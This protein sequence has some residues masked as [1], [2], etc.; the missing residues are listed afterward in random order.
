M[1]LS[2]TKLADS[3]SSSAPH[4]SP[5]HNEVSRRYTQQQSNQNLPS[6]HQ[7]PSSL[8]ATSSADLYPSTAARGNY[9]EAQYQG[10]PPT[11]SVSFGSSSK[12][13]VIG[14][15]GTRGAPSG[16][17]AAADHHRKLD[18]V[19]FEKGS[20]NR[21]QQPTHI[22]TA[23]LSQSYHQQ[24][25]WSPPSIY[26][27]PKLTTPLARRH[28]TFKPSPLSS[29]TFPERRLADD[30]DSNS[31]NSGGASNNDFTGLDL[32]PS[33][34]SSR[35]VLFDV[36]S[37]TDTP[38]PPGFMH[39][40]EN[41]DATTRAPSNQVNGRTSENGVQGVTR[42]ASDGPESGD[43][44]NLRS[45]GSIGKQSAISRSS[46]EG[47]SSY[48][49][50]HSHAPRVFSDYDVNSS[51]S[52]THGSAP[53][54]GGDARKSKKS[55]KPAPPELLVI[56]RPPPSKDR[57]PL[58]LQIQLVVP[59][60]PTPIISHAVSSESSRDSSAI[61]QRPPGE[62]TRRD[63]TSSSRSGTS[64]MTS[65]S[66]ASSTGGGRKVT[67]LY[68]LSFHTILPSTVL[69][70]GTDQKVAKF[71]KKGV[72]V[73]GFG[74]LEP[75]ELIRGLN[76]IQTL[77]ARDLLAV[78]AS[79]SIDAGI[80]SPVRASQEGML[81]SPKVPTSDPGVEPPSDS[82][83]E[84]PTSFEAMTPEAKSNEKGMGA[85]FMR[86]FKGLSV[87]SAKSLA[88][89]S[90]GAPSIIA[91]STTNT[92]AASG[93]SGFFGGLGSSSAKSVRTTTVDSRISLPASVT[94]VPAVRSSA[95]IGGIA[96][97]GLSVPSGS[98]TDVAPLVAG[99]GLADGSRRTRGY[100][101]T[102]KK[103]TRR[104]VD[105]DGNLPEIPYGQDGQNPVLRNVWRR[106]N[107]LNRMGGEER[108]PHPSQIPIRFEWTRESRGSDTR[109][110]SG[111]GHRR[112]ATDATSSALARKR[113]STISTGTG[114]TRSSIDEMQSVGKSALAAS[115]SAS[116]RP[117][118]GNPGRPLP[119]DSSQASFASPSPRRST[120]SSALGSNAGD[121]DGESDNHHDDGY[122]SD[123][124]DS[125]TP[126]SCHLVLG[127]DTRIPVGTLSPA[128]HHPKVVAQ[129]AVPFPL[130]DL[131]QTGL[132]Y[133]RAGL[134]REEIKDIICVTC[135]HLIIRESFGG[136][137]AVRKER[138]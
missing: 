125:E 34:G 108:H 89:S 3:S 90:G 30:P 23:Q 114:T 75:H 53:A 9:L 118:S 26:P 91:G 48:V 7:H 31:C 27:P 66:N 47:I 122:E 80:R 11:R 18:A 98:S 2:A 12:P 77:E 76:D 120:E 59:V 107:A 71:S 58:N 67:P 10:S 24:P 85:R 101:W 136:L 137:G 57:N 55:R 39:V 111:P 64:V 17:A 21:S 20:P 115:T 43:L 40:Q 84:P 68:N 83:V 25:T 5:P 13:R 70:A 6:K 105:E 65:A 52:G 49:N 16:L 60:A 38:H 73:D 51:A 117:P 50:D 96:S 35:T 121:A 78:R 99:A 86:K 97:T 22:D 95:S 54:D 130:P 128:P 106:F 69:D 72:D 8:S 33:S 93:I 63:S 28:S 92:G 119:R 104:V 88:D 109:S 46:S 1:P 123:P 138:R 45:Q 87:G 74:I 110:S 42:Q 62:L 135:L 44:P 124:E 15:P 79:G 32:I 4:H 126:W 100:F 14:A 56:V 113:L 29:P 82:H 61:V 112:A 129:L 132:C 81:T 36:P 116:L 94:G 102:V 37:R 41:S 134:T 133:D 131:S 127:A 103:L 19:A